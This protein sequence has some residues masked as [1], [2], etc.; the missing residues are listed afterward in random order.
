VPVPVEGG[1]TAG[2]TGV[3][4]GLGAGAGEGAGEGA[5]PI[6]AGGVTTEGP[7]PIVVTTTEMHTG[8]VGL[9]E[10]SIV[11]LMTTLPRIG[12]V[13]TSAWIRRSPEESFRRAI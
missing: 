6:G 10:E 13:A 7:L 5:G 1:V 9:F 8:E 2:V 4:A 3:G 12:V 11:T